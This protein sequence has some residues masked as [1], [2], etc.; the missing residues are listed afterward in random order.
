MRWTW[1]DTEAHA[2]QCKTLWEEQRKRNQI[3]KRKSK[4]KTK[5]IKT[6]SKAMKTKSKIINTKSKII[7]ISQDKKER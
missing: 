6:K 7:K 1:G 4:I 3:A 2:N 5:T